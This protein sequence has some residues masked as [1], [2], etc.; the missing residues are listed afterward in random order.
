MALR[1]ESVRERG[2]LLLKAGG[3]R[4]LRRREAVF[5]YLFAAPWLI[6][7]FAL[8]LGP[9]VASLVLSF[10]DY[11]LVAPPHPVGLRNYGQLFRGDPL[12]WTSIG[13]TIYYT[14][15]TVPLS[16]VVSLLIALL[17]NQPIKGVRVFRTIF[18]LPAVTSS[19]AVVLL[20][21]W[22]LNPNV[23]LVNRGLS[24]LG[25]PGPGWFSSETW[26]KPGL[27]LLALWS[28][29]Q[30]MVV[31]LAGLQA[32]PQTLY[33]AAAIDGA[34]PIRRFR[35]ITIPGISPTIF[36]TL[37][38]S[39]IASF[40]VFTPAFVLTQG[41]PLNSTLFYVLYMFQQGFQYLHMGYATAMAWVLLAI[42]LLITLVQF[43]F[44]GRWVYYEGEAR[45]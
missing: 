1:G 4:S 32:V 12:F 17:L 11:T 23:G 10:T 13:N 37:I 34:G 9:M 39:I 42:V 8:T 22:L 16:I 5:G 38:L 40:Q 30:G 20:W 2:S 6:G 28:V 45:R 41:G 24:L 33:E 44:S 43:A 21:G 19:V 29:G 26:S 18:Y 14:V 15:F 25:L 31:Y 7:F 3:L 36:F 27:I 35:H